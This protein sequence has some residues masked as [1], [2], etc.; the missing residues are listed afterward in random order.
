VVHVCVPLS[1]LLVRSVNAYHIS[2]IVSSCITT[3]SRTHT[4]VTYIAVVERIHVVSRSRVNYVD[5]LRWTTSI[6]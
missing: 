2:T 5:L 6:E 3:R 1:A 4:E